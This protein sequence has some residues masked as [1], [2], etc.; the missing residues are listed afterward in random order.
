MNADNSTN[1][2]PDAA[3]YPDGKGTLDEGTGTSGV[4]A[5]AEELNEPSTDRDADIVVTA[6]DSGDAYRATLGGEE[7]A[8]MHV[9]RGGEGVVTLTSTVVDPA[10]RDRGIGTSF[11]AHVLDQ[12]RDSG[13]KI[14]VECSMV[15]A[16]IGDNPEYEELRA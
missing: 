4:P 9:S 7:I 3:G 10:V 16:F 6:D 11:I 2:F 8:V 5:E 15:E 14:V 12:L 1:E 13:T